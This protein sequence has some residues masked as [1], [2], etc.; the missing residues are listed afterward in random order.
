MFIVRSDGIVGQLRKATIGA[1]VVNLP[2][3]RLKA[4][5]GKPRLAGQTSGWQVKEGR[6]KP[7]GGKGKAKAL[8]GA[9]L[10][11]TAPPRMPAP[12]PIL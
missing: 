6:L 12:P 4:V 3:F 1:T 10:W 8:A 2:G 11:Q 7:A 5:P 9:G